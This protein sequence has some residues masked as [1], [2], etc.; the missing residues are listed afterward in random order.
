MLEINTPAVSFLDSISKV[1]DR[2]FKLYHKP[3]S[4]RAEQISTLVCFPVKIP[5]IQLAICSRSMLPHGY[6]SFL[7]SWLSSWSLPK[8]PSPGTKALPPTSLT[9]NLIIHQWR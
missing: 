6:S 9:N 7:L 1:K 8:T 2:A 3:Y 5:E 4:T